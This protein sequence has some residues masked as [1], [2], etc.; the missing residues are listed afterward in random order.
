MTRS[1]LTTAALKK[2]FL[3]RLRHRHDATA[4]LSMTDG[5]AWRSR[6]VAPTRLSPIL[7]V[8]F[9]AL[10]ATPLAT[11]AGD[12][13]RG[14][15][16]AGGR[17]NTPG[18]NPSSAQATAQA[19]AN[20][21][22]ILS[23]TTQAVKAVQ[24]MQN[25]ARSSAVSSNA[26]RNPVNGLQLPDVPNGLTP[27]G[28][29]VAPGGVW[30]G[31]RQPQ[32]TTSGSQTLVNVQ[33]TSPQ[34]VL[35]WSSFNVGRNTLLNFDQSFGGNQT[36]Q[37]IVFNKVNDPTGVPSQILG[38]IQA[39]GQ[40]F[41]IN[42]NGIIFSGS[43]QVNTH[44]LFASSLPINDNLINSGLLNNPNEQF[45]FSGLTIPAGTGTN[46]TPAFTP[47]PLPPGQVYGD[48]TVEAGATLT[49]PTTAS[50]VGGR[51]VLVGA[52]VTNNGAISTPDGQTILAAGLQV[53]FNAH[54]TNDPSLRGLDAYVGMV[55]DP[56]GVIKQTS[57]TAT[58]NGLLETPRASTIIT[59]AAV[60]QNGV[61]DSSTSVTLNGRID[62]QANYNS[63]PNSN[64]DATKP[65]NAPE[66]LPAASGTVTL[67]AGSVTRILPEVSSNETVAG[68]QLALPSLVN[69]QGKAIHLGTNSVLLAPGAALPTGSGAVVPVS[70]EPLAGSNLFNLQ[71]GVSMSAGTW[72]VVGT[73]TQF[74]LSGGQ[75][76]VDRGALVNV[77]GSTD[78]SVPVGQNILSVQ[79]RGGELAD[80]PVQRDGVLRGISLDIDL[81]Q[82]GVFNGVAWIGTPL[83]NAWGFVNLIQRN[84]AQLT[85][86]GGSV[87]LKAGDSVVL[88]N[89]S[90]IDVSGGYINYQ[91]GMVQTTRLM[92]NGQLVDLS[93]ATPDRVYSGIYTGQFTV[94][95]SAWG[96]TNQFTSPLALTGTHFEQTYV[97][98]AAGGQISISAAS[99]ALDGTLRGNTVT[100]P[101]QESNAPAGGA[102]A[103]NIQ[104][105][106]ISAGTISPTPPSIYFLSNNNP[107][108]ADPFAVDST[109][110]PLP[111][112]TDR[113]SQVF[114]DPNLVSTDGFATL[115]ISNG[116]GSITVPNG[117]TLKTPAGGSITLAGANI[118]VE[119][120]VITPAGSQS[121]TTYDLSPS[122][123]SLPDKA[124]AI[125]GR[126]LFTL[127]AKATLSSAG[128][129]VDDRPSSATAFQNPLTATSVAL[130]ST[131]LGVTTSTSSVTTTNGGSIAI[132]SFSSDLLPG[133]VIDASGGVAFSGTG[134]RTYGNGGSITI[135]A[136]RDPLNTFLNGGHLELG[137]TLKGFAGGTGG[138]LSIQA[139]LIQVGGTTSPNG[140]LVFSPQFF[141]EGGFANF[142][143]SGIGGL[144]ASGNVI[145][146]VRIVAGTIISP[147]AESYVAASTGGPG[148][149]PLLYPVL[150]PIGF[151]SPVSLT[152]NALGSVDSNS[153]ATTPNLLAFRGDV[154]VEA[155]AVI[156]T[157]PQTSSTGGVTIKGYTAT[158]LGSII[159]PGGT[160]SVTGASTS[161]TAFPG[162]GG[163]NALATVYLGPQ[164]L[165][166]TAGAVVL[167]R[168]HRGYLSG[169][170]L[171]GGNINISGNIVADAGAV[172]DVSGTSGILDLSPA[173]SGAS[174]SLL[175]A[176]SGSVVQP[177]SSGTSFAFHGLIVPSSLLGLS[178][179][180]AAN[181][182]N[183]SFS[184]SAVM[185]TRVD[186]NGGSITLTGGELL[187][188]NASL[189]G[190]AGGPTALGGNLSVSSGRFAPPGGTVQ[191]P[192]DPTLIVVQTPQTNPQPNHGAGQSVIGNPVV[193]ATGNTIVGGGYFAANA[194]Q[195]GGF[196]SLT[197]GGTV[198]FSGP[199]SI[200]ARN[201]LTVGTSGVILA[202]ST[203][204]LSAPHVVLGQPFVAPLQSSE[205]VAPLQS[206]LGDFHATPGFGSGSLTISGSLIDVGNLLLQNIGHTS[207]IADGGDIRGDGTFDVAGDLYLRA[208]QIYPASATTFNIAAYDRNILVASSTAGSQTVTL[209]SAALPPGFGIGAPL[210]GS[211]VSAISGTTVT[212]AAGANATVTSAE[213]VFAPGSGSITIAGSGLRQL[214]LSA[215]GSLNI[216]ASN[217]AQGGVLRA[218]LGTITLG[219]D[220]TGAAPTNVLSGTAV[221]VAQQITLLPN[222]LTSVS[223]IDPITGQ[224]VLIPD[225][226]VINGTQWIDA[227]GVNIVSAGVPG[228][229]ITISGSKV[230]DLAGSTLDVR[231]GGD[232]YAYQFVPG[233]GGSTDILGS[234]AAP[235]PWDGTTTYSAGT[236]VTFNGAT[237]TARVSTS[238]VTP[239]TSQY[240]SQVP[241]S[242]AV[243]PGYQFD[244]APYG[245][246]NTSGGAENLA[247]KVAVG[248][249]SSNLKAGQ[250]VY[251]SASSGLPAGTYTLLPAR[252]ALLPGAVLVTP[253]SGTPLGTISM[254]DG[255]SV[256]AGYTLNGFDSTNPGK[257]LVS[258]FDVASSAVTRNRAQ[259]TDYFGSDYLNTQISL[260]GGQVPRLPIDSGTV[261]ISGNQSLIL[262]GTIYGRSAAGGRNAA[263][264]I[265]TD[266]NILIGGPNGSAPAGTVYLN[267]SLLNSYGAESLLIGGLRQ[268][269]STGTTITVNTP[270][271]ELNNAGAP[272]MGSEIMLAASQTI[273]LDPGAEVIQS[274]VLSS[275]SASPVINIGNSAVAGSGNGV[276]LRV[277]GLD[278]PLVRAGFT[279]SATS[280]VPDLVIS[281]GATVSGL[282]VTLDSTAAASLS[283]AAIL[284]GQSMTIDAGRISVVLPG[285]GTLLANPGLVLQGSL[286]DGLAG[287]GRLSLTGYS[288]IDL[289]GNGQFSPNSLALHTPDLRG[290]DGGA[291][292]INTTQFSLDNVPGQTGAGPIPPAQP[293]AGTLTVNSQ[294]IVIGQGQAN[295]DQYAT[296]A[297]NASN[298][299]L[300]QGTG[301]LNIAGAL[302]ITAPLLTGAKLANQTITTGGALDIEPIAGGG[303]SSLSSGLAATLTLAGSS[304]TE[305]SDILLPSGTL[306]LHATGAGG[307][308]TVGGTLGVGGI[309]E[310]FYDLFAYTDAGQ[311]TLASDKGNVSVVTGAKLDVT[312]SSGGG[313]A[314]TLSVSAPNGSFSVAN[315]TMFGQGGEGGTSGSFNLDVKTVPNDTVAPIDLALDAG[316]FAQSRNYRIRNVVN[317][318]ANTITVGN[319]TSLNYTLSSDV[320]SIL[321]TGTINA[322]GPQGGSINLISA[323]SVTLASGSVL[324]VAGTQ[325]FSADG[326]GGS[327]SLEAGSE[328]NGNL[329]LVALGTG[330]QVNVQSGSTI[331][332]SVAGNVPASSVVAVA[333][334]PVNL[335]AIDQGIDVL[336]T[337]TAGIINFADGTTAAIAA[338]T[339][340]SVAG[341]VSVTLASN[342]TVNFAGS[343]AKGDLTGTLHIR[344]PQAAGNKDLQVAPIMGTIVDASQIVLEGYTVIK[345]ANGTINSTVETQVLTNGNAFVGAN[346]TTTASYT[347]MLNRLLPGSQLS[348]YS[349]V[350]LIEPGVELVNTSGDLT[351]T[352][353]WDLSTDRFGPKSA[354]GDLTLR[355]SGNLIF[356]FK[357]SLSD[358]FGPGA[359]TLWTANLMPAGSQSWSYRLVAG[360]DFSATDYH[361]VQSLSTLAAN[362]GS[363]LLGKGATALPTSSATLRSNIIP[364]FYQTIRTGTGSIDIVAGRDVQLLNPLATIYTA[365]TQAPAMA[366]FDLPN[367]PYTVGLSGAQTPFYPVFYSMDGGRVTITAQNNIT[368]LGVNGVAD[369]SKEMPTDWLYRRD[370]VDPTTGQ[371]GSVGLGRGDIASTTWWVDFSNFFEGVGALGGG[372]VTMN[373]GN[374]IT[375]V[376]AVIPTN[377]R[378]PKGTPNS[379]NLLE[380]GGGDLVVHAGADIDGGVYYVERGT[381]TLQA[382][383]TIHTNA[384][385]AATIGAATTADQLPTTLFLGQGSFDV[386]ARGN[387]LLGPVANPFL[388]PSGIDNNFA[389]R[390]YFSTYAPTDF[391]DVSSLTGDVTIKDNASGGVG[392]LAAWYTSQ[393][394]STG[395]AAVVSQPWLKTYESNFVPGFAV[396]ATLMPPTLNV[397]TFTGN[398]DLIGTITLT[399]AATG[400]LNLLSAGAVNGF[401]PNTITG[402]INQWGAS[403]INISDAD[404]ANIPSILQ[405]FAAANDIA[406]TNANTLSSF[407]TMFTESGS[408]TGTF[409][410][411]QNKEALHDS[412]LLHA[413]DTTPIHIYANGGDVSGISLFAPKMTDVLASHDITDIGLYI[414]NVS[415]QDISVVSAGRDIILYD[416]N[417]AL[418]QQAQT[419]GNA[420]PAFS[421]T[422]F[423]PASPRAGDVQIN[424]PGTVEVLAG[425]N[426][427]LGDGP[428]NPDGTG[429]GITSNGNA[430]NPFLPFEGA[431][432]IAMAGIGGPG[433]LTQNSSLDFN[434][435]ITKDLTTGSPYLAELGIK[436]TDLSSMSDEQK[437]RVA[438]EAFYLILRDAGRAQTAGTGT[439]STGTDAITS[440]F[441]TSHTLGDINTRSRTIVTESGGD[442][443]LAAPG[444]SLT[445]QTSTATATLT[446]PG[447]ITQDGGNVNIFTNSDVNLGVSRIFTLRGGNIIIWSS[448]GN[449]AAGSSPKTVVSAP[450]TRVL[451]D[452]VSA[453]VKTDL[454]GLATGGGIGVLATVAGV[455][456]GN[457]DLVAP[458]GTVDAGDAGIRA[459]GNLNIAATKVLNADNI[460]VSG[461]T[462]GAPAAVVPAAPNIGGLT[463]ASNAGAAAAGQA[464]QTKQQQEQAP[465]ATPDSDITVEVVGYGGGEGGASSSETPQ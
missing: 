399:P 345:P 346:G 202:N 177:L 289:Y 290:A 443:S 230:T 110:A 316:A 35:T 121:F 463:A 382:G 398:I 245:T 207:L 326:K 122:N 460:T 241:Q 303:A 150:E 18:S 144:D 425:R 66:F 149:G 135:Q 54:T 45:L 262:Q 432:I 175:G 46:A 190:A 309:T 214:P 255:S 40:V 349:G 243:I 209:A 450:P 67:G 297:F 347:A 14:G 85:T 248:Y 269:T 13:L 418:R 173:L 389:Y 314:G 307:N 438:L 386:S 101:R 114:L 64:Y 130:T 51:V 373:A 428:N 30:Q 78:V 300:F 112:R 223:A 201:T 3:A 103:I 337:T 47:D 415:D 86:T 148:G 4:F 74:L 247:S 341:A 131:I 77:A 445:L 26:G 169:T 108:A 80:S 195:N 292:V 95:H 70:S 350:T 355:T 442:I 390:S 451:I 271:I 430:R 455:A 237:W 84:V 206:S 19:R 409:G 132:Q 421:V 424:G 73:T 391:V 285:A 452:P 405:P 116:D 224:G 5:P 238:G 318:A 139:P 334:T 236:L 187:V 203:V 298:G 115:N 260:N 344:A 435:F 411:T 394:F 24:A 406:L 83:A 20:A 194:F 351:L 97:N 36:S 329:T 393:Y 456:P 52:N 7:G 336:T 109:G 365:G 27:G 267:A 126:G 43:S 449:I 154:V 28:L 288:S 283:P 216:Y 272:L 44:A 250:Q 234:G 376:D 111:L 423:T 396:A 367:L 140:A 191:T 278:V 464:D 60:N 141:D 384:T 128:L 143:L 356:N 123:G 304:V 416:P 199:V 263:V 119:G 155:G 401:Q 6:A 165:L 192:L 433:D 107:A 151:R 61:I 94:S 375:N 174:T 383:G 417:S 21:Q 9:A 99:V 129:V 219:W 158:V 213:V 235:A 91:G 369:S 325:G 400:T 331:I 273:T 293:L 231:G 368:H 251:L 102:L 75:I 252:Y 106:N 441:G 127:G 374:N 459:T 153:S 429:V 65:L 310:Q 200:Q 184:G 211:T 440:L 38:S 159:A 408:I 276:F 242:F 136:G 256:V 125:P 32:Q 239:S 302:T 380:L 41:V 53:G 420:I 240:W 395:K 296:V 388:L 29:V 25:V 319:A 427:D 454:A 87:A 266:E 98:G 185:P 178:T 261:A 426:L 275:K 34:A 274:G 358:G 182:L 323:G 117:V 436:A 357:D 72:A 268:V 287:A 359:S 447:I 281:A 100:G 96:V 465:V 124:P 352:N 162:V 11:H 342:G 16:G 196:D 457:V 330:P 448:T 193:D 335:P 118:D 146:A 338:N 33:Q 366:D 312:A 226:F 410:S 253:Q 215:T 188:T 340:T 8:F 105:Q 265:S 56:S 361:K 58:N 422:S 39:N 328:T 180:T 48:V 372:N 284:N 413:G 407:S 82:T 320:G 311:I 89:G 414:Q 90:T 160:I 171:P 113:R 397:T 301:G 49:A 104:E 354:A 379:S 321:A 446:P 402:G 315:N 68:T 232:L 279:T 364:N 42:R 437:A 270:N 137:S 363:L 205:V 71:A 277:S 220:G 221:P 63:T 348:A 381:G 37:W 152:F 308:V 385:R 204:N 76:Y 291:V 181:G 461:T 120:Q 62:L 259:Y 282:S 93:Q 362:S 161:A 317:T 229:A 339:P 392:S 2:H 197:L 208:G 179:G 458:N 55:T 370:F 176:L 217:I 156:K 371:F 23:R 286:L 31:A 92:S 81:R 210:L 264:D 280:S 294:A 17:G 295:I 360:A 225:G 186:S 327:V 183:G 228:K 227:T 157:D 69:I 444:G 22:D 15:A 79:F 142:T 332:L 322:S 50:H 419:P 343:A 249:T 439:Y 164:S 198:Q 57:G 222:S 218:P 324:T 133:S 462:T 147:E 167:I 244:Y 138:S 305:N 163:T 404:P 88:Q 134:K 257:S 387:V 333:N 1:N 59:G 412:S 212:L 10:A 170:V 172:L 258:S 246:F 313:N 378:M 403:T 431:N 434:T 168:D 306:S 166:S 145:P 254:T 377:A 233:N 299:V 12:L 453:D 189:L 353:N